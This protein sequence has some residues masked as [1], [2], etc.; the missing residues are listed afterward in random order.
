MVRKG[1]E[2]RKEY[3]REGRRETEGGG[4]YNQGASANGKPGTQVVHMERAAGR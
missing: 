3:E 2:R 1:K 4:E